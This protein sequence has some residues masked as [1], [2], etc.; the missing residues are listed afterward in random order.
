MKLTLFSTCFLITMGMNANIEFNQMQDLFYGNSG[1]F[2]DKELEL[3]RDNP[4]ASFHFNA[5]A[6]KV[7]K[8]GENLSG[9]DT[10]R[11]LVLRVDFVEDNSP[12]TTGNGKF[13]YQGNGEE[14][15]NSDSTH[16]LNYDPPHDS[17]YF[18]HQME[19][20]R[21]YYLSDTKN[22][23]YVQYDIF[24]VG[25]SAS[26]TVPHQM[27]YYGD[28]QNIVY[29]LFYL[30]RDA[31][32]EADRDT[33]ANIDFSDYDAIVMFH[34]GSMWQTDYGDSPYDLPAV[35]IGG[36]DALFG[37]PIYANNRTDSIFES[38][39]YCETGFQDGGVAYLQGGLAHEFG[40]QLGTYDLYDVSGKTM[41]CNGWSLMGTG[42]WNL[43]GL[44]PP[45][46]DVWNVGYMNY[47][48]WAV[49]RSISRDTTV[50]LR[51]RGSLDSTA[52]YFVK[53]PINN[54]EHFL[55]SYRYSATPGDTS[56]VNPDSNAT[57]VWRDGV[58]VKFFDYDYSLPQSD[59][60]G[61]LAIWHIDKFKIDTT[62]E[63]NSVNA[64]FPRGVDLEEAD[65]I[66]DCELSYN[67]I[68][69]W[70]STF[71]GNEYD[72]F[73]PGGLTRFDAYTNPNSNDNF[74]SVT[75]IRIDSLVMIGD[76]VAR[77]NVRFDWLLDNFPFFITG[78]FDVNS[79]VVC[80]FDYDGELELAT[81]SEDGTVYA[82]ERDGTGY[83]RTTTSTTTIFFRT[84]SESYSSIAIAEAD[85]DTTN[86]MEVVCGNENGY[87]YAWHTLP[88]MFPP[89]EVTGFP[90]RVNARVACSPALLDIDK[91]GKKEI[92]IGA[93]DNKLYAFM[94][95]DANKDGRADSVTGF[96][97]EMG[98]WVWSTP[99][100]GDSFLYALGGD[101][102]LHAFSENNSGI[103]EEN[104]NVFE[105]SLVLTTASLALG[106]LDRDG[107]E[108][109]VVLHGNGDLHLVSWDGHTIW[110]KSIEGKSYV[111]SPSLAD[112]DGDGFLD[113]IVS[114]GSDL[115][116]F[117]SNGSLFEGFPVSLGDT[118]NVQSSPVIAD[119][120]GDSS[121]DIV[122]GTITGWICGF[123]N[124][125]NVLGGFPLSCGDSIYSTPTAVDIDHDGYI[126]LIANVDNGK[127]VGW[128]L[129]RDTGNNP[130]P[131]FRRSPSH[132]LR[133]LS[134][135][136][137][138][139]DYLDFSELYVWP[140]P[141]E[142][143]VAYL[144]YTLSS[145]VDHV[146][147]TVF[148]IAGD[149]KL[150]FV[151]GTFYGVNETS[152]DVGQLAPGVYLLRVELKHGQNSNVRF[153]KMAVIK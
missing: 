88:N 99:A 129:G 136:I 95:Q 100:M 39:M 8:M 24:P 4:L 41:G 113:I 79:P 93:N 7:F 121:P 12:L 117:N 5:P 69:D 105:P 3:Y 97:M 58:M 82:F 51:W 86:G 116:V 152:F 83:M 52:V 77:F 143:S 141:V 61:G 49:P 127:I 26:Y 122:I 144:R 139:R 119:L 66:Q 9:A 94:F 137:E 103:W 32:Y 125:G 72:L 46:H 126:D 81:L 78:T 48:Y 11:V 110:S 107:E 22:G 62:I 118:F 38:V 31:V 146:E 106:D 124:K 90:V 34:A 108:E 80:D 145:E 85:G 153:V 10:V 147:V 23:L 71:Y 64:G 76:T 134:P 60:S 55:I 115:T 67:Q 135:W 68:V 92:L 142:G 128:S 132:D 36:A 149:K 13:N 96:P 27:L 17:S 2:I 112:I 25:D 130:W 59:S 28:P 15:Y 6:H 104:W 30:L 43:D 14:E 131:M 151:A 84:N 53:V 74:G 20:L 56:H 63:Y 1:R 70:N 42:N 19:A 150:S 45:H 21:N 29:G 140:N 47:P 54:R 40:H 133:Q 18:D 87:I 16:N 35:W 33:V 91:N 114:F 123:D 89:Q 50:E 73:K 44:V 102:V 111:T 75:H 57:R 101:G 148:D 98:N 65:G 120:N 37:E 138:P 109:I